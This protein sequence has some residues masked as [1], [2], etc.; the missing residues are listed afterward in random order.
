MENFR[1]LNTNIFNT[2][3]EGNCKVKRKEQ[4]KLESKLKILGKSLS[5]NKNIEEYH[6]SKTDLD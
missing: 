4:N 1:I 6:M 3:L 5:C 2:L